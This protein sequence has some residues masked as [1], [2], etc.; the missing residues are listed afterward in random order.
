MALIR[1]IPRKTKDKPSRFFE[2]VKYCVKDA[3]VS[4]ENGDQLKH[5]WNCSD[6]PAEAYQL[7]RTT[8]R[9]YDQQNADFLYVHFIQSFPDNQGITPDLANEI[10]VELI[11]SLPEIFNGF[12]IIMGTHM[13]TGTWH[14][15]FVLNRTNFLTGKRWHQSKEDLRRIKEK[16]IQLCEE[17]GITLSWVK[18]KGKATISTK[19]RGEFENQKN[20]TSWKTEMYKTVIYALDQSSDKWGFMLKMQEF[21][22]RTN[23]WDDRDYVTFI[24]PHNFRC[25]STT[26]NPEW[27]KT[28]LENLLKKRKEASKTEGH[29]SDFG[30]KKALSKDTQTAKGV[31]NY[32]IQHATSREN[33]ILFLKNKGY[34]VTWINERKNITIKKGNKTF[35]LATL[36]RPEEWD[37][38]KLMAQFEK[39][40]LLGDNLKVENSHINPDRDQQ[41]DLFAFNDIDKQLKAS[42]NQ[43]MRYSLNE[44]ELFNHMQNLGYRMV[45]TTDSYEIKVNDHLTVPIE[46]LNRYSDSDFWTILKMKDTFDRNTYYGKKA[47]VKSEYERKKYVRTVGV[48]RNVRNQIAHQIEAYNP[49]S[50]GMQHEQ[51]EGQALRE[52]AIR[53]ASSEKM[54]WESKGYDYEK[55]SER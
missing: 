34:D 35:R 18:D 36:M 28:E 38:E 48:C 49:S 30:D 4:L 3:K 21:G 23:W 9:L 55:G 33:F 52:L 1:M 17:K 32:A 53:L 16:S 50:G 45:K 10:G 44:S 26:L 27:C 15:D 5:S 41:E 19:T 24:N 54:D 8:Q 39:N 22:Y 43:S 46:R 6:D 37:K 11:D 29:R 2:A 40:R 12:E 42:F 14:N 20:N 25:R 31:V 51:L 13:D 47:P 7:M